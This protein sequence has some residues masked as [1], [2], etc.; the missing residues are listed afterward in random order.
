MVHNKRAT[1]IAVAHQGGRGCVVIEKTKAQVEASC[2]DVISYAGTV[3]LAAKDA[4]VLANGPAYQATTGWRNA[5]LSNI[6]HQHLSIVKHV[7]GFN[8]ST[9]GNS[10]NSQDQA[11]QFEFNKIHR[12]FTACEITKRRTKG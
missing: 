12:T 4:I 8:Y 5:L 9:Y 2:L 1:S 11:P 6:P 10:S 3:A 7:I